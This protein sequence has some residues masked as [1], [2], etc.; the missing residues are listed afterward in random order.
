LLHLHAEKGGIRS[1]LLDRQGRVVASSRDN[2]K[3]MQAFDLWKTGEIRGRDGQIYEWHPAGNSVSLLKWKNSFYFMENQLHGI[4]PWTLVVEIPV[5]NYQTNLQS[6]SIGGLAAIM[7]WML[8]AILIAST[9]SRYL[10]RPLNRLAAATNHVDFTRLD[11]QEMVLPQSRVLEINTLVQNFRRMIAAL[12]AIYEKLNQSNQM[13]DRRVKKRTQEL[14]EANKRMEAQGELYEALVKALS[15]VGEGLLIIEHE[16]IVYVNGAICSLFGYTN[17]EILALPSF[18]GLVHPD[19]RQRVIENHRRRLEVDRKFEERYQ[20][21]IITRD[22]ERR[23]AEIAVAVLKKAEGEMRMVVVMRDITER[24]RQESML[25]ATTAELERQ[26]FALDQHSIVSIAD[27]SGRITYANDK[28]SEISQYPR[29]ELV[30]KNH[31]LIKSG[32]HPN[33]FFE[34]MWQTISQ[35]RVWHGEIKNRKKDGSFY[36][37]DSTI[38]PFLD[39]AGLPYQY[40]SIRTDVTQRKLHDDELIQAKEAAEA[41]NR[42]KSEFLSRM[43]HE[44]RTPLNAILGFAQLLEMDPVQPLTSEQK[45]ITG[46]ILKGGWHLLELINEVL[47]LSRIEAGRMQ[48]FI[49]DVQLDELVRECIDLVSPLSSKS[50]IQVIDRITPCTRHIVQADRMRLKQALLNIMSN[51]IKYN[52]EKGVM[53]LDCQQRPNS[54]LRISVTDEGAGISEE[55]IAQLFQPFNRLVDDMSGIE[56]AGMGLAITKSLVELMGGEV[57]ITSVLGEG[58]CFWIELG[59]IGN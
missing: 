24:K 37:A 4:F 14:F 35:G 22:D 3:P 36:W 25:A 30:G 11:R 16:R 45:E 31:R 40:V 46:Q 55:N 18:A 59:E 21:G 20:V 56:G 9:I 2:L 34:E 12:K 43:S 1:T 17:A 8:F 41:G 13:L 5:E 57:G 54:R 42:V 6:R 52:K 28:F 26:K 39:A 58:S 44:L 38:V 23:E 48:I 27:V 49:E 10:S 51:A 47:D 33:V 19:D 29:E 53:T 15:E 50:Q 32:Y 7:A